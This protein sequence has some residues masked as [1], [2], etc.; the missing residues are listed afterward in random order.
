MSFI[1][2]RLWIALDESMTMLAIK[3]SIWKVDGGNPMQ[4]GLSKFLYICTLLKSRAL[5]REFGSSSGKKNPNQKSL[6][7]IGA[8]MIWTLHVERRCRV[9]LCNHLFLRLGFLDL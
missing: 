3:I 4:M 6:L 7:I 2:K 1:A 9:S 8:A 5:H